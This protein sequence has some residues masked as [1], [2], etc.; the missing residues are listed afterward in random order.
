MSALNR[1]TEVEYSGRLTQ[2]PRR[3]R[4]QAKSEIGFDLPLDSAPRIK[5][6]NSTVHGSGTSSSKR[7]YETGPDVGLLKTARLEKCVLQFLVCGLKFQ[8][9]WDTLPYP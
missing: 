8:A 4:C 3:A 7:E 5:S 2:C 6:K 9:T 1:A